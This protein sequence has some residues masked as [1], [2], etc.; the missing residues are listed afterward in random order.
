M[1]SARNSQVISGLIEKMGSQDPDFRYMALNDVMNECRHEP[2]IPLTEATEEQLVSH[3]LNLVTDPNSEVKNMSIKTLA[4][5]SRRV[6]DKQV[7]AMVERLVDTLSA[8][9]KEES[10]DIASLGLKTLTAEVRLDTSLPGVLCGR[11]IPKLLG[12]VRD[13]A[14]SQELVIDALDV[15]SEIINRF[16]G[17]IASNAHLQVQILQSALPF[18]RHTRP[19]VRK[20]AL[21]V[22]GALGPNCASE[23]FTQL[24][25]DMSDDL[26]NSSLEINRTVVQLI[27][28]LA[29]TSA[30]RLGRRLPQ[31]MPRIIDKLKIDNDELRETV[32]Q[33]LETILLR[34]P[35]EVTP[36]VTQIVDNSITLLKH[37]PNYALDDEGEEDAD[38]MD[39]DGDDED[40]EEDDDDDLDDDYSDDEDL[41]WKVRR[42]AAKVLSAAITTR[43]EMLLS[44]SQN[45]GP[46]LVARF[47]ERE[48]SVRVEILQS[49]VNLLKQVELF[50]GAAQATEVP[51]TQSVLKRKLHDI[52][53]EGDLSTAGQLA[54]LVPSIWKK[55]SKELVSKSLN[56]RASAY[57]VLRE[58][59]V[60]LDGGLD[61]QIPA[62]VRQI[63]RTLRTTDISS[64]PSAGL[65]ADIVSFIRLLVSTHPP[66]AFDQH[67]DALVPILISSIDDRP[68][69][70]TLEGLSAC[71]EL[72]RV[73]RP[74]QRTAA[75]PRAKSSAYKPYIAKIFDA[76]SQRISKP[77][78]D[79]DIRARGIAC[80][81]TILAHAGDDLDQRKEAAC[82]V[83]LDALSNEV[84]RLA[85]V[86]TITQVAASPVCVG[87]QFEELSIKSIPEV[88]QLLRKSN[89]QLKITSFECLA[90][91]LARAHLDQATIDTVV[92]EIEP[93]LSMTLRSARTSDLRLSAQFLC[94]SA[95]TH[96][97]FP[98]SDHAS[99]HICFR[100]SPP[101]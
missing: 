14:S 54:S 40:E 21:A 99:S 2:Y 101:P 60:V 73:C 7:Q 1:A 95:T 6:R 71:G 100:Y 25:K 77:G 27:T 69:R 75:S 3:V 22:L 55:I 42:T 58:L 17:Y 29:R 45:I 34:C 8:K 61:A 80:V 15:V 70:I 74:I 50:G 90:E 64:G 28:T 32:L 92:T 85:A 20:R 35:A 83:L 97:H 82:G 43:S 48:E 49:F 79:Q 84:T 67:L 81:G 93:L 91:I 36:F 51:S 78:T 23:V 24:A 98:R 5:L 65:K 56:T 66:R 47:S 89:R 12:H 4:A 33:A 57:A 68:H 11:T 16:P 53:A 30:R 62:L 18:L 19:A 44:F 26:D 59:I 88:A 38:K 86:R 37:D 31:F 39:E 87:P 94:C 9:G 63:E 13:P 76:V 46:A 72:V 41:S 10:R 96:R 52:D